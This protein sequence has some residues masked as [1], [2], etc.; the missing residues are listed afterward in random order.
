VEPIW[1][2]STESVVGGRSDLRV[3]VVGVC[4]RG[5][6]GRCLRALDP[7]L[8][9]RTGDGGLGWSPMRSKSVIRTGQREVL[10][11][12]KMLS[13]SRI[14]DRSTL[15]SGYDN[16]AGRTDQRSIQDRADQPSQALADHRGS[17]AGYCRMGSLV[18]PPGCTNTADI[19]PVEWRRPTTPAT[20]DR[21]PAELSHQSFIHVSVCKIFIEMADAFFSST[22]Q[23]R[24]PYGCAELWLAACSR[25]RTCGCGGVSKGGWFSGGLEDDATADFD[26]VVGEA[27]IEPA[28]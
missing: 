8:A 2:A 24:E 1:T 20:R 3:D 4:L 21:P 5:V 26:G 9:S 17:R 28:Q 13:T 25:S 18:Q 23:A 27:L 12:R 10:L 15:R 11:I 16:C 7:G 19:P 22:W 6:R 14:C